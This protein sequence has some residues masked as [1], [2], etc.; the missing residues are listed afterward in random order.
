MADEVKR[1]VGRPRKPFNLVDGKVGEPVRAEI[2]RTELVAKVASGI[3]YDVAKQVVG[4]PDQPAKVV[5][6]S[7]QEAVDAVVS[8]EVASDTRVQVH[9]ASV[10]LSHPYAYYGDDGLMRAWPH[11]A[12]VTDP[13]EIADLIARK[14]PL[15]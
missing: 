8:G 10:T 11:G 2:D 7:I 12:V 6:G 3:P 5:Y 4:R 9:P 15:K 1:P 13:V 14:A